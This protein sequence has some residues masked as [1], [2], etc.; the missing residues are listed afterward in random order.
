[1]VDDGTKREL[2]KLV[3]TSEDF[4][5]EKRLLDIKLVTMLNELYCKV[6]DA[7]SVVDKSRVAAVRVTMSGAALLSKS[8][9]V[10][11]SERWMLDTGKLVGEA[12]STDDKVFPMKLESSVE[13]NTK[14]VL[15]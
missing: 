7:N 12:K 2:N 3:T 10:E 5:T 6:T 14:S 13:N 8:N 15:L 11:V 1:M 9:D 4:A